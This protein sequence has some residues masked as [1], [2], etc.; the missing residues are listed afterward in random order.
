MF[1]IKNDKNK[2]YFCE[3]CKISFDNDMT[4]DF[5]MNDKCPNINKINK[6]F[7]IETMYETQYK[8]QL[9]VKP[10]LEIEFKKLERDNDEKCF[11]ITNYLLI[12]C[13]ICLNFKQNCIIQKCGHC[14]CRDC[15]NYFMQTT[16]FKDFKCWICRKDGNDNK[17][18]IKV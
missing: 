13:P 8:S 18:L 7:L 5:I 12:K 3:T 9:I 14:L 10:N 11:F 6:L 17:I 4:H 2:K 15:L 1:A 16:H